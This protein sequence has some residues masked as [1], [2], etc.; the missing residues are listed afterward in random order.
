MPRLLNLETMSSASKSKILKSIGVRRYADLVPLAVEDG[1][2]PARRFPERAIKRA[3]IHFGTKIN[4]QIL[5][6]R[7]VTT[8]A[9]RER[10]TVRRR[11]KRIA[12]REKEAQPLR[13][14]EGTSIKWYD[15]S[16]KEF[17]D[18][19]RAN[20]LKTLLFTGKTYIPVKSLDYGAMVGELVPYWV[21]V[22]VSSKPGAF[23]FAY[24]WAMR[25]KSESQGF[26]LPKDVTTTISASKYIPHKKMRQDY[27]DGG[28]HCVFDA[29]ET[30]ALSMIQ[31]FPSNKHYASLPKK[32][33]KF[34]E[35]YARGVP[36][37]KMAEVAETLNISIYILNPL[38][39][40][41]TSYVQVRPNFAIEYWN[42]RSNHLEVAKGH[43]IELVEPYELRAIQETL[44]ERGE[45]CL[46]KK[47]EGML[48]QV[49][50]SGGIYGRNTTY[51]EALK[52][53]ETQLAG[54]KLSYEL[55][56]SKYIEA[57]VH[58]TCSIKFSDKYDSYID[59]HKSY[60]KFKE[61]KYYEGFPKITDFRATD[62]IQ[63]IGYYTVSKFDWSNSQL[64]EFNAK[65]GMFRDG[66]VYFSALLRMLADNGVGLTIV[67][68]CWGASVDF[69][70]GPEMLVK[71]EGVARY[72]RAVGIWARTTTTDDLYMKCTEEFAAHVR[73]TQDC[74]YDTV[75]GV[76]KFMI[77]KHRF[78]MLHISGAV[79][80]YQQ[81]NLIDQLLELDLASIAEVRVDGIKF[82]KHDYTLLPTFRTIDSRSPI[83]KPSEDFLANNV[84][85]VCEF[86]PAREHH[87][88]ELHVGPG[89][90]G[91][92][93]VNLMDIGLVKVLY[94]APT[95]KL[96]RVKAREF[97][98]HATVLANVLGL[99]IGGKTCMRK[100][101]LYTALANVMIVDE[102]SMVSD[103][104]RLR[105]HELY[106]T[107]K[108][109]F[110][111]DL[112]YQLPPIAG[113]PM[114]AK[115]FDHVVTHSKSRRC[116]CPKLQS[117]LDALRS[118]IDGK[119]ISFD[120]PRS[121]L[122]GYT[123]SDLILVHT[124]KTKD[125]VN[126]F[127]AGDKYRVIRTTADFC[128]GDISLTD[129]GSGNCVKQHA[130]TVHS[131]QGETVDGTL[132]IHEECLDDPVMLYTAISRARR[133]EQIQIFTCS[134]ASDEAL[135]QIAAR[136]K[137]ATDAAVQLARAC[138]KSHRESKPKKVTKDEILSMRVVLECVER[139]PDW[140]YYTED[141]Q[142][143]INAER[144]AAGLRPY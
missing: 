69:E 81:L 94:I 74:H 129:L 93:H 21:Q 9:R 122:E 90:C 31:E 7:E 127:V 80:A 79:Y 23:E 25:Y 4:D 65:F 8:Q 36:D 1:M 132:F 41:K 101:E 137:A 123:T 73:E 104:T 103:G 72:S 134:Q 35:M 49:M 54:C 76:A 142:A 116:V 30:R 130:F 11:E 16:E 136:D 125:N 112:G 84:P 108:F 42:A 50:W 26:W 107:V 22:P 120:L 12:Q 139:D 48:C 75:T 119:N 15:M 111:G 64:R 59:Q 121:T 38:T 110:C 83:Q 97:G 114:L 63:A 92:T 19:L 32:I 95:H 44:E 87:M 3:L 62:K 40:I 135:R 70:F 78:H 100:V 106:P 102:A 131:I 27:L 29:I 24:K 141:Q 115:S 57:G 34:R 14:P 85:Y 105:L 68:G 20:P 126:A 47:A 118:R 66:C 138:A 53:C 144:V 13:I 45:M 33:K 55:P 2:E 109:L 6:D 89:G 37:D 10:A 86:A 46:Y 99:M 60:T 140:E 113:E 98:C 82:L 133:F 128:N 143:I 52:E 67:G 96:E 91:K 77:P 124:H 43:K 117:L 71:D 88:T 58:Q 51:Q 28:N 56:V 18:I 17:N 61:T 5:A 39:G